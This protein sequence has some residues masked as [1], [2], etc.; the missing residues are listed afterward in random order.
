M[1]Y[2]CLVDGGRSVGEGVYTGSIVD[3]QFQ[4]SGWFFLHVRSWYFESRRWRISSV[5]QV[6]WYFEQTEHIPIE[7]LFDKEPEAVPRVSHP[8]YAQEISIQSYGGTEVRRYGG[9]HH[10]ERVVSPT[11]V[12]IWRTSFWW[13]RNVCHFLRRMTCIIAFA[14][15][16]DEFMS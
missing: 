10:D 2:H 14:K 13:W 5:G 12:H 11:F 7:T 4:R 9:V 3:V 8:R 6:F 16:Q 15:L 1:N